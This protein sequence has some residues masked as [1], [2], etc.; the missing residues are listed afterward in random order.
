MRPPWREAAPMLAAAGLIG[1]AS[2]LPLPTGH[3][4]A[5]RLR[6]R[7][8]MLTADIRFALLGET[9]KAKVQAFQDIRALARHIQRARGAQGLDMVE[10]DNLDVEIAGE[11]GPAAAVQIWTQDDAGGRDRYL[12][13]AWLD[14]HGLEALKSALRRERLVV[15]AA[16]A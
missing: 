6:R 2:G 3:Q 12:G 9:A 7:N 5:A 1:P 14:G 13:A 10:I 4:L 8:H 11:P 16:A 15:T